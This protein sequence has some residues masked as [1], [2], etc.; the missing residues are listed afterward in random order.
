MIGWLGRREFLESGAGKS[1]HE[2]L[3]RQAAE[4]PTS[5]LEGF[6]DSAYLEDRGPAPI[7]VNPFFVWSDV[8][9]TLHQ[10]GCIDDEDA[11][12]FDWID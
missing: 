5:W 2:E 12:A 10:V 7:N 11:F 3:E 4:T 6:W 8:G 9:H 1:L